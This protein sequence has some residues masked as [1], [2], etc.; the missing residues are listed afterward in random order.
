MGFVWVV[1]PAAFDIVVVC[2]LGDFAAAAVYIDVDVGLVGLGFA[3]A[4]Y[5]H[6]DLKWFCCCY[7]C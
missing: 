4:A 7:F 6:V 1:L 2:T 5:V 3:A